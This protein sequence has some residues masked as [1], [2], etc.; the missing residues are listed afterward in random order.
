MYDELEVARYY[1][2]RRRPYRRRYYPYYYPYSYSY[3][4]P[5]YYPYYYY[6]R[7]FYRRRRRRR[8][9]RL[10]GMDTG[11]WDS[12]TPYRGG[13]IV[14]YNGRNYQAKWWTQGEEPD[15]YVTS[16]WDTP[17]KEID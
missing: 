14:Y 8:P 10:Y 17:W 1:R 5:M 16:Q 15:M 9:G 12:D 6:D 13:D 4:Y 2:P 3:Y 7:P 11:A